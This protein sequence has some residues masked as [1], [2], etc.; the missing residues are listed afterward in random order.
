M[1]QQADFRLLNYLPGRN[2]IY[3]AASPPVA[4]ALE[5][6]GRLRPIAQPPDS[7]E[8]MPS[9]L[10]DFGELVME[11]KQVSGMTLLESMGSCPHCSGDKRPALQARTSSPFRR[12]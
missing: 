3:V 8:L 5:R 7:Y 12:L 6:F 11:F 2:L 10:Y 9:A 1:I 4:E